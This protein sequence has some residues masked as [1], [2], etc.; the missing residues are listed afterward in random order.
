M[1]AA[2]G[3]CPI[4]PASAGNL[5]GS[6]LLPCTDL[7]LHVISMEQE[8]C[9]YLLVLG[10]WR[11]AAGGTPGMTGGEVSGAS[12]N[13]GTDTGELGETWGWIPATSSKLGLGTT[14]RSGGG[15]GA[16]ARALC[17]SYGFICLQARANFS[18]RFVTWLPAVAVPGNVA[19]LLIW[20]SEA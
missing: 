8:T 16:A 1:S 5:G 6:H 15:V 18:V 17:I 7:A 10:D 11:G 19:W 20:N 2:S 9:H 13:G 12:H 14:W 3:K 4:S